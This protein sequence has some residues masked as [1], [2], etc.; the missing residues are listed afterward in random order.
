MGTI[1]FQVAETGQTTA[2]KT[3]TLPDADIDRFVA[4]WQQD[5]NTAINGTATRAQVLLTWAQATMDAGKA[6]VLAFEKQAQQA[7]LVSPS[8]ISAT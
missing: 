3:F 4:A 8:P 5:A 1:T 6:K 2:T 7:A